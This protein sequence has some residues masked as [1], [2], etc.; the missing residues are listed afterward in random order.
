V[1]TVLNLI[2][3]TTNNVTYGESYTHYVK[4]KWYRTWETTQRSGKTLI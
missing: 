4:M 2:E 3:S 1:I